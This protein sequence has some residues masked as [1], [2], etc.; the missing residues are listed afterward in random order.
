MFRKQYRFA[1]LDKRLCSFNVDPKA[2]FVAQARLV[3]KVA[4]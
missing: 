1:V 2:F 3:D 4:K